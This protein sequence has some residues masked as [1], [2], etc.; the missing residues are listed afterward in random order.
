MQFETSLLAFPLDIYRQW[1]VPLA[2]RKDRSHG[3]MAA[4]N[5][6]D[7]RERVEACIPKTGDR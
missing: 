1:S 6:I 3:P 5:T 7:Y 4:E 2:G